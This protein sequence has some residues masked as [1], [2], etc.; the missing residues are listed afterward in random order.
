MIF[1]FVSC[2]VTGKLGQAS[3]AFA[4]GHTAL[5]LVFAALGQTL[6]YIVYYYNLR[7]YPVWLVKICLL[8][9]PIF[10][11]VVMLVAFHERLEALQ[12]VGMG[13]VILGAV[14]VLFQQKKAD[15]K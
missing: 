3:K 7:H 14:G 11:S 12:Y 6:V 8:L 4:D 15:F 1:F 10:S 5:A 13:V 9:M 2:I